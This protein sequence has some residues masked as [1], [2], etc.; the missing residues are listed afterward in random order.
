MDLKN[1]DLN[2]LVIFDLL[3]KEKKVSGVADQLGLTQPAVS[4]SLKRLRNLLGDELFYRTSTGMEPTAHARQLAE[5]ISSALDALGNAI[6]QRASFDPATSDRNFTI[7]MSDIGE[8]YILPRLLSVL[9]EEAPGV[10]IT[11][12]RDHGETLKAGME[13]GRID[14]AI[15][16]IDNLEAGFFR[17]QIYRQG[18]VCVFRPDH[19]LAGRTMSLDDFLAAE[20]VLVTGTGS[21]HAQ[22]DD[23]IGKQGIQRKVRLRIPNYASLERL[24][25]GSDLIATVPE[26]LVQPNISPLSLACSRHPVQLPRL[27]VNQFWHARFH[28]DP[29]S[30]WLREV[31]AV[32]CALP[33]VVPAA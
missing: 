32:R 30:Q 33:P 1:F 8:I 22:V 12:V 13:A 9:A 17:R 27:S 16:L 31:I 6:S 24:L 10:S 15:G 7:R 4:R 29:A 28:R 25:S 18:Y 23:L 5:P 19:P 3:L 2:L 21:G 20:H 14:L 26:A 11:V